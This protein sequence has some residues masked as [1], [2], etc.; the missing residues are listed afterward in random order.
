MSLFVLYSVEGFYGYVMFSWLYGT[1]LGCHTYVSK[2]FC[3]SIVKPKS[4]SRCWSMI[5]ATQSL[6][7]LLGIPITGKSHTHNLDEIV[8]HS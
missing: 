5:Q 7:V 2:T 4:F 1:F 8:C 3:Y 6:P